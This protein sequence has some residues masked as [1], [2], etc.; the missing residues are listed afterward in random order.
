M[1]DSL[2]THEGGVGLP[3]PRTNGPALTRRTGPFVER[4]PMVQAAPLSVNAV[5]LVLVPV[6]EPLNPM[7]VL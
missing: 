7:S 1:P 4:Q 3:L 5:G 6:W 2:T